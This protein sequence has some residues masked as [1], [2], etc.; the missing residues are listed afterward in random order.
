MKKYLLSTLA[1]VGLMACATTVSAAEP[2]QGPYVVGEAGYSIGTS[3]ND[4]AAILGLGT[5][6]HINEFLRTDMTV[7]YR[8]WGKVNFREEGAK[9]ADVWSIPVLFNMYASY[10]IHHMF[11]VY[12]MG[13]IGISWNKTDSIENAKGRTKTNFAW[14]VGAG[15]DYDINEC[16]SLD[17]GYRFS[18]LGQARVKGNESFTGRGKQDM[19]SHDIKL[20]ARYYF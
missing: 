17:L 15:V 14:Q 1:V 4:D 7:S 11:D 8:G 20:S 10:P 2:I 13:G 16:W 5:G 18:D 12:A 9:K 6:Y 19:R 3:S